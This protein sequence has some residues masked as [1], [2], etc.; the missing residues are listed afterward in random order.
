MD[1]LT[2][3]TLTPLFNSQYRVVSTMAGRPANATDRS[4]R[5][6]RTNFEIA[7]DEGRAER[8]RGR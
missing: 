4:Q 8:D 6:R 3:A 1:L 7:A 5:T 2:V